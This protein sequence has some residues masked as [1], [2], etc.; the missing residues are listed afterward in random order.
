MHAKEQTKDMPSVGDYHAIF[1]QLS[2]YWS[3][4]SENC[5]GTNFIHSGA[6]VLGGKVTSQKS[7]SPEHVLPNNAPYR[8]GYLVTIP[9]VTIPRGLSV[10]LASLITR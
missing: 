9:G 6:E 8:L 7:A 5:Q 4:S 2:N 3:N 10:I 1:L